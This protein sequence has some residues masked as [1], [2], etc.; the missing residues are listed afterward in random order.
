MNGPLDAVRDLS[1]AFASRDLGAALACFA[2]GDD[3]GYAGSEKTETASGRDAVAVLLG[4]VFLRSEAYAWT[5]DTAT[6]HRYGDHAYVFAEAEG[7]V[8][9]DTG[10][11]ESF[12]YRVSGIAELSG[13]R[14]LW[15]HFQ[16]SEPA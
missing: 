13:A 15:R 12:P 1:E 14:W 16:G 3:I 7:T 4:E 2:A 11:A 9:T 6:V 8:R 10:E 5:A